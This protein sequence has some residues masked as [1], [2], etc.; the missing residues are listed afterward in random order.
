MDGRIGSELAGY[1]IESVVG[2][3]G[4][5]VVYLA[6]HLRLSR[7]VALKILPPEL[8]DDERFRDRFIHESKLAASL[9]HPHIVD[10]YDAGEADGL[11][12]LA[13]RY[14][15]GSDLRTTVHR[16]GPLEPAR[17]VALLAQVSGALD[18]AHERGLVHRDVKSANVLIEPASGSLGEHAYLTDF[19][20]TKRPESM[21]GL[22]KT[23]QFLGSVEY[24][25]PEQFEGRP[26]DRRTDLYSLGCVAFECLTGEVPFPRDS[27]AAVMYAH[28]RDEPPK[29]TDRRPELPEGLDTVVAKAMAKRPDDRYG[30]AT[31]FAEDLGT[32][33]RGE[34]MANAAP[35][36]SRRR[37]AALIAA[38]A[39]VILL[40]VLGFLLLKPDSRAPGNAGPSAGTGEPPVTAFVGVLR[41]T[42]AGSVASRVPISLAASDVPFDK[43]IAVGAGVVWVMDA[44]TGRLYKVNT[45]ANAVVGT[46]EPEAPLAVVTGGGSAWIGPDFLP[47]RRIVSRVDP[48]TNAITEVARTPQGCCQ[49]EAFQSGALWLLGG[50]AHAYRVDAKTFKVGRQIA[51]SGQAMTSGDG[52]LWVLDTVL[53]KVTPINPK[54]GRPGDPIPLA[55]TPAAV[56]AGGGA[57]WVAFK[58]GKVQEITLG[59][60]IETVTLDGPLSAIVYDPGGVWVASPFKGTVWRLDPED[61]E[62]APHKVDVGGIPSHLAVGEGGVWIVEEPTSDIWAT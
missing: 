46:L 1:R 5:G 7:K 2:R 43:T 42:P 17:A 29:V 22:T 62:N 12:Y 34:R 26:V 14:V 48:T 24:A 50:S 23:G 56:A 44:Q 28:L 25:A 40:G 15:S 61:P 54:S 33:A 11:V 4:M 19:G 36:G 27:E 57:L 18:A 60:G 51:I 9:D 32:A 41:L 20:L 39:G 49:A 31:D 59:G 35:T 53:G 37:R 47:D 16:E 52:R 13:M 55:G 38:A 3:G 30:S 10:I 8:A 58:E 45:Q 21:S 6:E